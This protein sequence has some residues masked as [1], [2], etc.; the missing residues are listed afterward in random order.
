MDIVT[1]YALQ[2]IEEQAASY[3]RMLAN[4]RDVTLDADALAFPLEAMA[5]QIRNRQDEHDRIVAI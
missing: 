4:G 3:R 5:I 2:L 1:L